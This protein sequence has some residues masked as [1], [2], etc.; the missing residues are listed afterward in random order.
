MRRVF[1]V[2]GVSFTYDEE[3]RVSDYG[4]TPKDKTDATFYSY[5]YD[6]ATGRYKTALTYDHNDNVVEA[7]GLRVIR[8]HT[9]LLG[10]RDVDTTFYCFQKDAQGNILALL[11]S[12]GNVVKTDQ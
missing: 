12:E 7:N 6:T 2:S 9:G 10:V 5:Q 8:D 1:F 4:F 3:G 11:D